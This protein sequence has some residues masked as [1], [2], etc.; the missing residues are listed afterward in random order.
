MESDAAVVVIVR[1][2]ASFDDEGTEVIVLELATDV[3]M[4]VSEFIR[5]DR[6]QTLN[7]LKAVAFEESPKAPVIVAS[8]VLDSRA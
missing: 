4:I 1:V 3:C 8:S 5:V 7:L 6:V 2:F